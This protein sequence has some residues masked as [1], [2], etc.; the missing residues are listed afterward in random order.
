LIKAVAGGGGKGMR[1]VQ[2]D[3]EFE[4][5]LESC[6]REAKKS[7]ANAHVL[8]EKFIQNPRH[9]EVQVFADTHGNVVHL[10]ERDCSLQRRHQKVVEEAPAPNMPEEVREAMGQAAVQAAKAIHYRG[11]GTIEFIADASNGLKKDSFYFM[12]MNTRLQV[13]HPVT[14]MI[15]GQD[16]VEWQIRVARGEF[17]PNTQDELSIKGHAVEVRL[18]AEDPSQNFMP[19]TGLVEAFICDADDVRIDSGVSEGSEVTIFY[20]PMIAKLITHGEDRKAALS[21]MEKSLEALYLKGLEHNGS[22]LHALIT[23]D[24]FKAAALDTSFIETHSDSISA[25][26]KA[27][28]L[29][30]VFKALYVSKNKL[31][32]VE[33][34]SDPWDLADDWRAYGTSQRKYSL[35]DQQNND[36]EFYAHSQSNMITIVTDSGH[37][38]FWVEQDAIIHQQQGVV[39]VSMTDQK[40][41]QKYKALLSTKSNRNGD[42]L[43]VVNGRQRILKPAVYSLGEEGDLSGTIKAPMPGRVLSLLVKNGEAVTKDQPLCIMEAMKMEV[44]IKAS[45]DGIVEGLSVASGDQVEDGAVLMVVADPDTQ[46]KAA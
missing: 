5:A 20:D 41:H 40:T 35:T 32:T 33:G 21:K 9:I 28:E 3:K 23:H 7:F 36:V 17:L 14:E 15:T 31:V 18:Y 2:D 6:K 10:F 43:I 25:H 26:M 46:S 16:L 12:E 30:D 34:S 45:T 13:E 19:Q 4:A 37:K 38:Q 22:F 8:I 42:A 24:A 27:D 29:E 1:L 44:T 39:S 11:A